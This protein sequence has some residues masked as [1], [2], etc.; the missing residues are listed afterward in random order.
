MNRRTTLC[1]LLLLGALLRCASTPL[2]PA[3]LVPTV[4]G[5]AVSVMFGANRQ[6][7]TDPCGCVLNQNGGLERFANLVYKKKVERAG[8]PLLL[9]DSGDTF[10]SAPQ[11]NPR[12]I[13]ESLAKAEAIAKSY[14]L[15]GLDVMTPGERDL[16]LGVAT[17]KSLESLSGATLVSAN[18]V[19]QTGKKIFVENTIWSKDG[20][21]VGIFGIADPDSFI[22]PSE[23][24][25]QPWKPV[26]ES[27]VQQLK[28]E[29]V[30]FIIVLSHLGLSLDRELAAIPGIDFIAGSHSQDVTA[31]WEK[32][33]AIGQPH[34]QGHQV[35]WLQLNHSG[36]ASTEFKLL[37]L[38]KSYDGKNQVSEILEALTAVIGKSAVSDL[39][40]H[41]KASSDRPYVAHAFTC[42]GCHQPQYDFWAKTKHASAY[43]VLY[44]KNQHFNPECIACHSL[45]FEQPGGFSA[46]A[47]P[48]VVKEKKGSSSPFIESWMK[49]VFGAETKKGPLDSRLQPERHQK[50]HRNYQRE[51]AKLEAAGKVSKWHIGVQCEHCHGNRNGHPGPS[52]VTAKKVSEK[53][54]L[55]CHVPP[56]APSFDPSNIN[57]VACPLMKKKTHH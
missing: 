33:T 36:P 51:L 4:Q 40:Q 37:D 55:Q 45:G 19:D 41:F 32:N 5:K 8:R 26:A 52:A 13:Q 9:V 28:R 53:A 54:C 12:R 48:V 31:V 3:E 22:G 57:R 24:Q 7:E 34:P 18:L 6:G 44:S 27:Q 15:M 35:G 38:D 23:V 16:A 46:I 11:L 1:F 29:K 2:D 21:R 50:L 49:T 43:L 20:V 39:P 10:F 17:L 30:D 56:N 14:R 47:A 25:V 42:R